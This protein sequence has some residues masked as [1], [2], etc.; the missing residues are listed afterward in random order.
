MLYLGTF[1]SVLELHAD[2]GALL[3]TPNWSGSPFRWLLSVPGLGPEIESISQKWFG[4]S[5]MSRSLSVLDQSATKAPPGAGGTLFLVPRWK[6][7]ITSVGTFELL[8][9]SRGELG[10]VEMKA[11][12]ILE[13]IAYAAIASGSISKNSIVVCGGGARS[14]IWLDIISTVLNRTIQA[15]EMA[16]E[17]AGTADIAARSVWQSL[18]VTR[19]WYQSHPVADLDREVLNTNLNRAMEYYYEHNWL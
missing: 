13:G 14:N 9:N 4:S 16:W 1:G 15:R 7:G 5:N 3:N 2:P 11:R 10:S 18:E 6:G 8:P 17:A 12:A 19:P